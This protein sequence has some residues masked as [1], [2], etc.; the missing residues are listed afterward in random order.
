MN[1]FLIG[2]SNLQ[3]WTLH[4][5]K[6]R[7]IPA[8]WITPAT[9]LLN[10][11]LLIIICCLCYLIIKKLILGFVKIQVKKSKSKNDDAI[12]RKRPFAPLAHLIPGLLIYHLTPVFFDIS[13][14]FLAVIHASAVLYILVT[15]LIMIVRVLRAVE[16]LGLQSEKYKQKPVHSFIQMCLLLVYMIFGILIL[17]ILLGRSPLAIFT[18]FGAGMAILLLIFKD[19][20]L[21]LVASIQ[22]SVNDMVRLGDWIE[23][24]GYNADG[25]LVEINLMSVKVRNWDK[26][27]TNVPTYTL[28]SNGFKNWREMQDLGIRRLMQSIYIDVNT[29]KA[30]DEDFIHKLKNKS[31]FK[32][33]ANQLKWSQG[34]DYHQE[35]LTTVTNLG[36]FR[37]YI[38][39]YLEGHPG[40]SDIYIVVRHLEQ[41]GTGLPLGIYAFSKDVSWKP[42]QQL[43]ADIFEHFYAIIHEFELSVFQQPGG[44]DIE[45]LL[46]VQA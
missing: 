39:S 44:N 22:L 2:I 4:F 11:S 5:L 7:D 6:Q 14:R 33:R 30:V 8:E 35:Q 46:P 41:T 43:Q 24:P 17:S 34:G 42:L 26:T 27:V 29:V 36:L 15:L 3:D 23:V 20:I 18:A 38:E 21:G 1:N 9:I 13:T 10:L 37:I 19:T 40:I 45:K 16:Y 25:D 31:L 28:V 12:I 32:G